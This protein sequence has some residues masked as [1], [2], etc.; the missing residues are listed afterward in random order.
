MKYPLALLC[1]A[2]LMST[3]ALANDDTRSSEKPSTFETLDKNSDGQLSQEELAGTAL[4]SSFDQLDGNSDG[5][6]SKRE[7]QRN[8]KSKPKS[9]Y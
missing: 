7:F 9:N 2:A 1:S 4:A 5:Q 3:A 6:V 8:T